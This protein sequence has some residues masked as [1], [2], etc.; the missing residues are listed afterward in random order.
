MF[1]LN[2]WGPIIGLLFDDESS[3]YVLNVLAKAGV[4]TQQFRLTPEEDF[5]HKTRKRAYQKLLGPIYEGFSES[6]KNRLAKNV[7]KEL[8]R[9]DGGKRL[10]EALLQV[11]WEFREDKLVPL[12]RTGTGEVDDRLPLYRRKV[13][14]CNLPNLVGEAIEGH[15]PLSLLMLDLDKFKAVNDDHGHLVGDEVL[16]DVANI[17]AVQLKGKGSVYRYGGEELVIL[18]PNF[19]ATESLAVGEELRKSIEKTTVSSKALRITA[20]IGVASLPDHATNGETLLERADAALYQAKRLGRNLVRMTGDPEEAPQI[21][22]DVGRRQPMPGALS[23]EEQEAIRLSYFRY[24]AAPCPRDR[25]VLKIMET[26]HMGLR[27]PSLLVRC[28]V[29]AAEAKILGI[30]G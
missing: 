14:D 10:D 7:A 4:P 18:L 2:P 30:P 22:R 21:S 26:Q 13:F 25:A 19:S 28:P 1:C 3:D 20:S 9:A 17:I 23:D 29:C 12:A 8:A 15:R 5:S 27:T 6:D 24:G 11:G 16:L